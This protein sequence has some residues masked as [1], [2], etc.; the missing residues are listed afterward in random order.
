M[1]TIEEKLLGRI[2][3]PRSFRSSFGLYSFLYQ[4]R[5]FLPGHLLVPLRNIK[6]RIFQCFGSLGIKL[7]LEVAEITFFVR[8]VGTALLGLEE[9]N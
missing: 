7:V 6:N 1:Y 4:S 9:L 3:P 8:R 5:I 2:H